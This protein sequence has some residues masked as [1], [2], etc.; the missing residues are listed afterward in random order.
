VFI[1]YLN[2]YK[3]IT[4]VEAYL[5]NKEII[6]P[7]IL[8]KISIILKRWVINLFNNYL[9]YKSNSRYSNNEI[10]LN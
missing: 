10:C 6:N 1:L 8:I 4:L 5:T 7:I 3:L 2:N 9:I